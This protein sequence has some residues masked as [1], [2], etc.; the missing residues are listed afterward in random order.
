MEDNT[1]AEPKSQKRW[2]KENSKMVTV[3]LMN[4][5]DA[6]L[7]EYLDGKAKATVIKAALREYIQNHSRE[8]KI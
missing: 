1:M 7:I 6:D 8:E 3:K 5:G 4:K 2:M